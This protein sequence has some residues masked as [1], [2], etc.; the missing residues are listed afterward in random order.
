MASP[1]GPA[2]P[3]QRRS[4]ESTSRR[5]SSRQRSSQQKIDQA[6]EDA[7]VKKKACCFCFFALARPVGRRAVESKKERVSFFFPPSSLTLKFSA[8][9]AV[10]EESSASSL[11]VE[12]DK[13][14]LS[15]HHRPAPASKPRSPRSLPLH[16]HSP[17][18]APT[19]TNEKQAYPKGKRKERK[20]AFRW[21]KWSRDSTSPRCPC[22][23]TTAATPCSPRAGTG[24]SSGRSRSPASRTLS[25]KRERERWRKS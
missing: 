12:R 1:L 22:T 23:R 10:A 20:K 16:S 11:L 14:R 8:A 6:G 4:A 17:L 13:T 15:L 2:S 19:A 3:A 9:A 21:P 7:D 5:A 24:T 25:G 18:R